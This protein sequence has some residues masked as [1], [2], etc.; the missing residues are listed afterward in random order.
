M[1]SACW[2]SVVTAADNGAISTSSSSSDMMVTAS[3]RRP[4]T[5]CWTH[6]IM[7][8]VAT[9]IMMAHT[10][11]QEGPQDPEGGRQQPTDEQDGEDDAR[12]VVARFWWSRPA[13][14]AAADAARH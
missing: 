11:A 1:S 10:S 8:Q 7:G 12:E 3:Q 13:I 4:P 9:T 5:R 2:N 6:S 14:L